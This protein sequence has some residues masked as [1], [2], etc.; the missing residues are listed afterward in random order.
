MGNGPY[1]PQPAS[2]AEVERLLKE[3]KR[4]HWMNWLA[5]GISVG[6]LVVAILAWQ[7]PVANN[8]LPQPVDDR[9]HDL[10]EIHPAQ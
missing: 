2:M 10:N 7:R 5:L 8:N 3:L 6:A 1:A 9:Q 4:P